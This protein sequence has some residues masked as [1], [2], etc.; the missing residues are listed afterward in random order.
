MD[1]IRRGGLHCHIMGLRGDQMIWAED[2]AYWDTIVSPSKSMGEVQEILNDFG[3]QSMDIRL[4]QTGNRFAWV[5]RFEWQE[6]AFRFVFLPKTCQWPNKI[7]SF[8]GKRRN[9][10]EQS[11]YQMGRVA[12]NLV[13]NVLAAAEESPAALFGYLEVAGSNPGGI[14]MTAAELDVEGLTML[15]P[16][17]DLPRLASGEVINDQD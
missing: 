4:G 6:K 9:H 13:K 5:V 17:I 2:R 3:V 16:G 7:S 12:V 8:G 14:P 15:L 1:L 10:E 11:H